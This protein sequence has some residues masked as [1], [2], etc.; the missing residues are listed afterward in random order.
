LVRWG[1]ASTTINTYIA[2]EKVNRPL[3][4]SAKFTAGKNE[5]SPIPQGEID[6]MNSDGVQRLK[7]NPGY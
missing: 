5:Y 4:Q 7:Q 2:R 3:K 6:N 1:I